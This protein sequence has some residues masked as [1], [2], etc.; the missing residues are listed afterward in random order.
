MG[1]P[2][3]EGFKINDTE[4]GGILGE[5]AH[6]LAYALKSH[7][8]HA[9]VVDKYR[10]PEGGGIDDDVRD[11]QRLQKAGVP[12]AQILSTGYLY[13][14]PDVYWGEG[15]FRAALMERFEVGDRCW[16]EDRRAKHQLFNEVTIK[17][18][19]KVMGA[20]I[21]AGVYIEDPQ[22]L[23]RS[24]GEAVVADPG[25]VVTGLEVDGRQTAEQ[26]ADFLLE[27]E[28]VI[29]VREGRIRRFSG[30]LYEQVETWQKT[31]SEKQI[32]M[33]T[34]VLDQGYGV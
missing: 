32:K 4:L 30:P 3:P 14:D 1:H 24:N 11:L 12:C 22:F 29:G 10:M 19:K 2:Y 34:E 16:D 25:F 13:R 31:L 7:S 21:R 26:I 33:L 18:Y 20:C 9:L 6:R 28:Y 8:D 27:A 5:G 17:S 15:P 23:Y